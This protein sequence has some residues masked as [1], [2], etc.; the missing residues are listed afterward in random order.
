MRQSLGRGR[1]GRPGVT[2]SR[3]G[4]SG[5]SAAR[6]GSS[7]RIDA[8]AAELD[9]GAA[10]VHARGLDAA[11]TAGPLGD[12]LRR[13]AASDRVDLA[14]QDR[15]RGRP[16]SAARS[17]ARRCRPIAAVNRVVSRRRWSR[18]VLP[19]TVRVPGDEKRPG[20]VRPGASV[21]RRV[22][23]QRRAP[24][25]G[26]PARKTRRAVAWSRRCVTSGTVSG[27]R[28][29]RGQS[30][31]AGLTAAARRLAVEMSRPDVDP[32]PARRAQ[33]R[34]SGRRSCTRAARC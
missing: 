11:W 10:G 26:N 32:A 5:P 16:A 1:R 27:R 33:S 3:C 20:A 24:R 34:N 31:G 17:V 12:Q 18:T 22:S 8:L 7:S 29:R 19:G 13:S 30:A 25:R 6:R 15:D 23:Q 4:P 28:A 2:A 9:P 14:A 21:V